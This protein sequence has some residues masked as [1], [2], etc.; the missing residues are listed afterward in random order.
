MRCQH[1]DE[2]AVISMPQHRLKLCEDHFP[3]WVE[4]RVAR[5]IESFQ[6]FSPD[7]RLLVAVSGGKDSLALWDIL[8][9]LGYQADGLYIHLGIDHEGYS[10]ISQGYAEAF[11]AT[12]PE[13]TLHVVNVRER[14]GRSIPEFAHD[15]GRRACSRCGMIKRYIMNRTAREGDYDAIVTGHNLDDEAAQLLQNNLYWLRG[16]LQ[17]QAPVLP[18][19][20]P[21]LARKAKPLC[22]LHERE[23]A[24]YTLVRGIEYVQQEC[25]H[26]VGATSIF[27]KK[28]L[29]DLE[30]RSPGTKLQFYQGFV[31]ARQDGYLGGEEE[32]LPLEDCEQCGQPTTANALC[33]FC[34]MLKAEET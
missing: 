26:S 19:S 24:A 14:Y 20:R 13:A 3:V 17:R 27:H 9:R 1:C 2:V 18:E 31:R 22:L 21:G 4:R 34:R 32:S 25:P 10:D 5:T 23:S 29:N 16:Y 30:R 28:I 15:G 6:M 33:A 11:A 7:D 12:H 8:L